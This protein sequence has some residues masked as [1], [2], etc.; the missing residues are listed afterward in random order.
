MGKENPITVL[1][2]GG[3]FNTTL[4]ICDH[5]DIDLLASLI[6][7]YIELDFNKSYYKTYLIMYCRHGS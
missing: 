7:Q 3:L 2:M 4:N 5:S 6:T 1:T